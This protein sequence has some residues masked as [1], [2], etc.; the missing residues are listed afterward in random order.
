MHEINFI[1]L[2]QEKNNLPESPTTIIRTLSNDAISVKLNEQIISNI[3][4][5]NRI[6]CMPASYVVFC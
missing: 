4:S 5:G 2:K 6:V 3:E 1:E